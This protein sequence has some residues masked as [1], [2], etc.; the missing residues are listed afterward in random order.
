MIE[1]YPKLTS[2]FSKCPA[3]GCQLSTPSAINFTGK[4][5]LAEILC[6][7]C[8]VEYLH[9]Y[10]ANDNNDINSISFSKNGSTI[11]Y[12]SNFNKWQARFLAEAFKN[13][14]ETNVQINA[15][16]KIEAVQVVLHSLFF[17]TEK[18]V[19]SAIEDLK[20]DSEKTDKIVLIQHKHQHMI[21]LDVAE[22][23]T[24]DADN[25]NQIYSTKLIESLRE[26][27]NDYI[28]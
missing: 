7:C 17:M 15:E 5:I 12:K 26:I 11:K 25:L 9:T 8:D 14:K 16:K 2:S 19:K 24:V 27:F 13:K 4:Y 3:C 20:L 10:P 23:W 18:A 22:I 28:L 6:S 21:N 1:I